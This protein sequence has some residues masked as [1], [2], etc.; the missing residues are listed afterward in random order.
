MDSDNQEN[1]Y[2]A[3]DDGYRIHCDIC[4]IIATDRY[5][6]NRLKSQTHMKNFYKKQRLN[7]TNTNF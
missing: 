7:N 3:D 6:N 1:I 4:D 5:Y 2:C